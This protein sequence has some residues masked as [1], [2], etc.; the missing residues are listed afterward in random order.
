[1]EI[2]HGAFTR[3]PL[4]SLPTMVPNTG[5]YTY[6]DGVWDLFIV[7]RAVF[8]RA[9]PNLRVAIRNFF[10]AVWRGEGVLLTHHGE[11]EGAHNDGGGVHA[12]VMAQRSGGQQRCVCEREHKQHGV[13]HHHHRHVGPAQPRQPIASA[14]SPES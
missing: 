6:D 7:S 12:H 1:V 11:E 9:V 2:A 4:I 10:I 13:R 5:G 3:R 8:C 14:P